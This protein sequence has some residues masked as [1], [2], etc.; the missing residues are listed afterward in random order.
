VATKPEA[1]GAPHTLPVGAV[2]IYAINDPEDPRH[3]D[4]A[5]MVIVQHSRDVGGDPLYMAAQEPIAPPPEEYKVFS[6]GYLAYRLCA[7]WYVGNAP[8][9]RFTD[10]GERVTVQRF[11]VERYAI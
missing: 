1:P 2:V 6:P 11:E 7:G 4:R 3:G 8:L 5:R 9:S 10:T